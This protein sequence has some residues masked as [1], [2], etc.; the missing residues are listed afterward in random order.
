MKILV[1]SHPA[2]PPT[3]IKVNE[4]YEFEY[5]EGLFGLDMIKIMFNPVNFEWDEIE[6]KDKIVKINKQ[7]T[8]V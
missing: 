5:L 4:P 7:L 1:Y 2:V 3:G 6:S 8:K